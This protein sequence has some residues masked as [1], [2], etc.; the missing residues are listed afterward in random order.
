M[1]YTNPGIQISEVFHAEKQK[2]VVIIAKHENK[3]NLIYQQ[4]LAG[5]LSSLF[6]VPPLENS[7]VFFLLLFAG[8]GCLFF[9]F[10]KSPFTETSKAKQN[11]TWAE[12]SEGEVFYS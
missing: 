5:S 6:S 7:G 3:D 12:L 8:F 2:H 9:F 10:I 4:S 1:Y 11:R